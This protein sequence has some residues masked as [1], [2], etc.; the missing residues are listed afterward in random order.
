[1]PPRAA[2]RRA[3]AR[4]DASASH[5]ISRTT[6][7]LSPE[8][9][10]GGVP[11]R[12]RGHASDRADRVGESRPD[13]VRHLVDRPQAVYLDEEALFAEHLEHGS[14]LA[15]VH[16][17]AV[18]DGFFGV[19]GAALFDGPLL[20]P[21]HDLF[22]VGDEPQDCVELVSVRVEEFGEVANLVGGAR[23]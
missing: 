5:T 7:A 1:M 6:C 13:A 14:G 17:L 20:Q 3:P 19:V 18:P 16:L 12:S 21:A 23:V 10:T 22:L 2:S 4:P 15:L 11:T 9:E 8:S